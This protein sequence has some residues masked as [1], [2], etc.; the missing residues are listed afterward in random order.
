M[1]GFRLSCRVRAYQSPVRQPLAFTVNATWT[2][3]AAKR[4]LERRLA[5]RLILAPMNAST[6]RALCTACLAELGLAARLLCACSTQAPPPGASATAPAPMRR[7]EPC[8]PKCRHHRRHLCG[9]SRLRQSLWQ[10]SRSAWAWATCS[11]AMDIRVPRM[12]P[13]ATATGRCLPPAADLARRDGYGLPA[14]GYRG[15][16]HADCPTRR[17]PSSTPLRAVRG[18]SRHS[19]VTR[20]LVHRF[21]EHQ[22]QIDGGKNDGYAAWRMR[23]ASRWATGIR[24]TRRC[25][26]SPA[27]TSS[28]TISF[29]GAFGGSF[30]NH[31]YLICACAPEYP[32]ADT[33]AA[34]SLDRDPRE[35][36]VGYICRGSRP[37]RKSPRSALDGPPVF[38]NSGNITPANYFGDGK[39]YAVN[40]MQPPFQPSGNQPAAADAIPISLYADPNNATTLPPQSA[41][42]IGDRLDAKHVRG[43]GMRAPGMR[44]WPTAAGRR[45]KCGMRS[46]HRKLRGAARIFS[47]IISPSTTTQS[48]IHGGR[49]GARGSSQG[50][51]RSDRGCRG[52]PLAAGS[53]YKPQGTSISTP[54]TLRLPTAMPISR[55]SSRG[56]ARV[57]SGAAW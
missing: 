41:A 11:T 46:T 6:S 48:S 38:A 37:R 44:R 19:T 12:F 18:Y 3:N 50:L 26:R 36:R 47:R 8:A 45:T 24:A 51:R 1:A 33:A 34:T 15:A 23:A 39:F 27:S 2:S 31:Q 22:M 5:A 57:R 32:Y 53:F 40:T 49:R 17:S 25:M 56:F 29:Q 13:R 9:K 28:P 7:R 35:G 55:I 52:G 21:F 16:E 20:D 14:R 43:S 10:L 42:T 4:S 54:A 30:L